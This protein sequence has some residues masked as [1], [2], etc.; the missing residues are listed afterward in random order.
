MKVV[1]RK[2]VVGNI[3][4]FRTCGMNLTITILARDCSGPIKRY[5]VTSYLIKILIN[6]NKFADIGKFTF[7]RLIRSVSL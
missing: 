7:K 1:P 2:T 5:Q 6:S 4:F 3:E